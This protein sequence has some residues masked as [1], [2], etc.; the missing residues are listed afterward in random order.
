VGTLSIKHQNNFLMFV[1]ED[2]KHYTP[3]YFNVDMSFTGASG[4]ARRSS[5]NAQYVI[6]DIKIG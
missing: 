5:N 2:T 4:D 3:T 1:D 6:L